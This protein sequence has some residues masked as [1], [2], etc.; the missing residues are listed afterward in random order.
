MRRL[1]LMVS[2]GQGAV[3]ADSGPL[4]QLLTRTQPEFA[5]C[6]ADVKLHSIKREITSGGNR[7]ICEAVADTFDDPPF[8]WSE[9]VWMGWPTSLRHF[10]LLA[11][12]IVNY[13]TRR[14][15][16]QLRPK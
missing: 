10:E 5:Q 2:L 12:A 13:S 9:N 16:R 14:V 11:D 4:L 7:R 3:G 8:G 6:A 15:T 1:I